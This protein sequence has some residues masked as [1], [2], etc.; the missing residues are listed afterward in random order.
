[1]NL[2]ALVLIVVCG[3]VWIGRRTGRPVANSRSDLRVARAVAAALAAVGAVVCGLRGAWA[4]SVLLVILAGLLGH[5]AGAG[6]TDLSG[7]DHAEPMSTREALA[8]LGLDAGVGRSEIEAAYRNQ[9]RRVHPDLGGTTGLAAQINAA[10]E[11]LL[12]EP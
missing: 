3:L 2:V 9:M 11:R 12:R 1:M 7:L 8:I 10:R 5:A 4:G 6:R